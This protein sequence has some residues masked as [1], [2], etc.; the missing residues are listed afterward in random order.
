MFWSS[1]TGA[2]AGVAWSRPVFRSPA[3][4][5]ATLVTTISTVN[6]NIFMPNLLLSWLFH[7]VATRIDEVVSL[8]CFLQ[9]EMVGNQRPDVDAAGRDEFDG[10]RHALVLLAYIQNAQF[11]PPRQI[12]V[13]A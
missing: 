7:T 12:D 13:E 1:P 11:A 2:A 3:T 9:P 6:L 10:R 4:D 8:R 5:N